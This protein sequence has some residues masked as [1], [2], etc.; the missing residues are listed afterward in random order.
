VEFLVIDY[1]ATNAVKKIWN[2][3]IYVLEF[4]EKFVLLKNI[5]LLA[6]LTILEVKV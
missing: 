2:V 4:V 5:V 6:L 3:D 1:H